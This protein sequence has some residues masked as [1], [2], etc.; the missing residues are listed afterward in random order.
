MS[1]VAERAIRETVSAF[2][3]MFKPVVFNIEMNLRYF[4][5]VYHLVE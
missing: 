5:K 1:V 3:I 2:F 4:V